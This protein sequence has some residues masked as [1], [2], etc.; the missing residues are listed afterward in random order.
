MGL[1]KCRPYFSLIYSSAP[2]YLH[3][4][5]QI[6]EALNRQVNKHVFIPKDNI[7]TQSRYKWK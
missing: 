3:A 2:K 7:S 4:I 1:Y 5:S 6:R